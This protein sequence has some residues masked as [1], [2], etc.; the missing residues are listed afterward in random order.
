MEA[1]DPHKAFHETETPWSLNLGTDSWS[2]LKES[3]ATNSP[4]TSQTASLSTVPLVLIELK[5]ELILPKLAKKQIISVYEQWICFATA[6]DASASGEL[7]GVVLGWEV[8]LPPPPPP[9]EQKW[10]CPCTLR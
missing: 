6:V 3:T 9:S 5:D 8:L 7:V 4:A 2:S 10:A 1:N